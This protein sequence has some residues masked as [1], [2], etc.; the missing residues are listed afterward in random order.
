MVLEE[1]S[2]RGYRVRLRVVEDYGVDAAELHDIPAAFRGDD[3]RC[4]QPS[5]GT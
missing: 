5:L 4:G 1:R 2:M 3:F